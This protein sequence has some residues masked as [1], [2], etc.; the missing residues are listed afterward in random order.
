VKTPSE[1]KQ[2]I[3]QAWQRRISSQID[4]TDWENGDSHSKSDSDFLM[5]SNNVAK[6]SCKCSDRLQEITAIQ[7]PGDEWTTLQ[8]VLLLRCCEKRN[9]SQRESGMHA[10]WTPNNKNKNKA[11]TGM[12]QWFCWEADL[13][14]ITKTFDVL[15]SSKK[16]FFLRAS[17]ILSPDVPG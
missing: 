4:T 9:V 8:D 7:R 2:S 6:T 12:S 16:G 15:C 10:L 13:G 3:Q 17:L 11:I 1:Y 5:S 14:W